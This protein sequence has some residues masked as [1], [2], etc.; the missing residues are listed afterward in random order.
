[1]VTTMESN[2][3][4]AADEIMGLSPILFILVVLLIIAVVIWI[5]RR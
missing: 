3:L 5:V 1:M 2:A 4:L